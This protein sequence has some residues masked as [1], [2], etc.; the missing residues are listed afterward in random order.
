V[1][2]LIYEHEFIAVNGHIVRVSE[3]RAV[4]VKKRD[5]FNYETCRVEYLDGRSEQVASNRGSYVNGHS[6]DAFK[7]YKLIMEQLKLDSIVAKE[8]DE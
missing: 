5:G 7:A 8:R 6:T 4:T 2:E 1:S 3:I